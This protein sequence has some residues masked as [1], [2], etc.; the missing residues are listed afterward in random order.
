M[1]DFSQLQEIFWAKYKNK[2]MDTLKTG[3]NDKT[4]II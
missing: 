2:N 4:V 1:K 3:A